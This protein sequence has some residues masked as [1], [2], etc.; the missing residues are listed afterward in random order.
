MVSLKQLWLACLACDDSFSTDCGPAPEIDAPV[1]ESDKTKLPLN[2]QKKR[3]YIMPFDLMLDDSLQGQLYPELFATPRT[4][5]IYSMYNRE[6]NRRS[7]HE[8]S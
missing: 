2:W 1:A 6:H 5:P 7:S 3:G 4:L 8:N